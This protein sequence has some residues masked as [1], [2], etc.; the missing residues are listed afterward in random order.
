M[1]GDEAR[2]I[3]GFVDWLGSEGWSVEREVDFCDVVAKR[4]GE[5]L[6]AEAKGETAAIGLDVDTMYGQILRRMPLAADESFRFA[7]V[8]PT[9]AKAAAVRVPKRTRDL[10]RITVFEVTEEGYVVEI[11]PSPPDGDVDGVA[12]ERFLDAVDFAV[13]AHASVRQERKGTTYPY[14]VHPI[15]VGEILYRHGCDSDTVV[16]GL[17]HDVLEDTAVTRAELQAAFGS[18]VAEIVDGVTEPDKTPPRR[19]RMRRAVERLRAEPDSAVWAVFAADKLDNIRSIRD[20]IAE[21]GE[22]RTWALFSAD[23]DHQERYYRDCADA[24]VAHDRASPLFQLLAVEVSALFTHTKRGEWPF[25]H[26]T[27][28]WAPEAARPY[29]A[30]PKTQWRPGKSAYELAHSWIGSGG[31]PDPVARVLAGTPFEIERIVHGFFEREVDLRTPGRRTQTDLMILAETRLGQAVIGVEG[32]AG[33]P[34]GARVE[35]WLSSKGRTPP[36]GRQTRLRGLCDV[37]ELDPDEVGGLRYQLLHR[38]VSALYEAERYGCARALVLVHS[39][40]DSPTSLEDFVAFARA[41]GISDAGRGVVS[42]PVVRHGVEL[43]LAWVDDRPRS[44]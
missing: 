37:L 4:D 15:R 13:H 32:K 19:V 10:L 16:A 36:P 42:S 38:T 8:V 24:L 9:C 43:S 14:I 27:E 25:V 34:F 12:D 30:D 40:V 31:V 5:T 21:R 7:V 18:R 41:L 26:A 39:F 33:E 3:A 28:L 20:T 11:D 44:A 35:D 29:L 2:V 17:L 6:F 22:N 1:R 23:R